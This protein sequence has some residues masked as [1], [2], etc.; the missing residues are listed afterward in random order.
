MRYAL[1]TVALSL[2]ACASDEPDVVIDGVDP[3]QSDADLAPDE[4][5]APESLEPEPTQPEALLE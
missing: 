1:L 2:S 3:V 5:L 4:T